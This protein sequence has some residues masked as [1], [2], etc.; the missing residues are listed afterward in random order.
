MNLELQFFINYNL[1]MISYIVSKVFLMIDFETSKKQIA[2]LVEEFKENEHYFKSQEFDEENTK[3]NFINKFFIALGWDVYNDEKAA[4]QNKEV[5]FE[6]S[7]RIKGKTKSPD[8]SFNFWGEKKFFVEAKAPH[9]NIEKNRNHA[10]QLKRYTWS[11]QLPLGI[12]TD[13]EELAIYEPKEVPKEHHNA[14]IDRIKYYK[15]TDYVDKW[16]EI[17]NIFSKEAVKQGK[18]DNYVENVHGD[19]KGTATVDSEFLKTIEEWRLELARNLANRN[20]DLGPEELNYAVQLIIDRI[21]F[22]R[23]AEDRGIEPYGQ[24]LGLLDSNEDNKTIYEKFIELC[25]KADEKYN[26]GLFHFKEEKDISL[27]ADNLTPTLKLDDTKLT[28]I[29]KGLYYPDCPYE[30]SLISTEILGN[31]YEQFLGKVIRLTDGHRAKVEEKPEVKKAGGVYYTPQYIVEYI[32]ENTIEELLKGKTPNQ[33]SQLRIVDPACG[34]GS[35]LLGAYQKLIDWH[36]EYY[37]KLEKPPKDTI[38][39]GKDGIKRL[40]IKEKKRILLKNIYGVDIDSQAVEVTKLSLLLKVLEDANKDA[41]EAQQKLIQERA[42]PYLGDNIKC[43]NSLVGNDIFDFDEFDPEEIL[44]INPFD[45]KTAFPKIFEQGGFDAVIGNPPYVGEKDHAN[46]FNPIKS[47]ELGKKYYLGKM[48]LFYFFYHKSIDICKENGLI[49][50]ITTNYFLSNKGAKKLRDDFKERISFLQIINFN[51][52]KVFEKAK[53]QHNL[54]A[55]LKKSKKNSIKSLNYIN[56]NT[57]F[58]N[59]KLLAKITSHEDSNTDIYTIP[60]ENLFDGKDNVIRLEGVGVFDS[61]DKDTD[62]RNSLLNKLYSLSDFNLESSNIIQGVVPNPD[63]VTGRHVNNFTDKINK[64]N[65]SKGDYVFTVPLEFFDN[66]NDFEKEHLK[67]LYEPNQLSKYFIP[68]NP[69]LNLI[70]ITNKNCNKESEIPN[71]VSHLRRFRFI[72]DNRRENKKGS[73]KFYHMHWPRDESYFKEGAKLISIRKCEEPTFVYTE[74]EAYFMLSCNIIKSDKIN[75]KVL[76]TIL[77]SKLITFWLKYRGKMKGKTFQIDTDQLCEIPL[78][79][80]NE[81]SETEIL[82][83]FDRICDLKIQLNNN[84]LPNKKDILDSYI[85]K[86]SSQIDQL[87][88]KLYDLTDE[89]I[90]IVENEVG[91]EF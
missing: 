28:W 54:I 50:F 47:T 40:T 84:S 9:E 91:N 52:L 4:P 89:E 80:V 7:V 86:T 17:Y 74:K 32:V 82:N 2:S 65:I 43:G 53:G 71:F 73:R 61:G 15:Y 8:Y 23:I 22:L 66:L 72:M 36:V 35:F 6:D 45:W 33:V 30:F 57:G 48:D 27:E 60:Q 77:N 18:Y 38:Y 31:I 44:E 78:K 87:V 29:I 41:L 90:A 34:S 39:E 21:I 67:P 46:I 5:R 1:H 24:L 25:K 76:T 11:A 58:S 69:N 56:H 75:L 85:S 79:Y 20:E 64:N 19:R 14:S 62:N 88:Y 13:F 3:I 83:L 12:L 42:L 49:S 81:D 37:S 26:S 10:F 63:R 51:E 70:Y 59:K 55:I 68:D 16:D